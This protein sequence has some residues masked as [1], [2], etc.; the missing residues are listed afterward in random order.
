[1]VEGLWTI[2]FISS[3]NLWGGGVIVMTK[4][5]RILGGDTGYYYIGTYTVTGSQIKGDVDI[6]Q[7]DP[8]SISV[9]GETSDFHLTFDGAFEDNKFSAAAQSPKFPGH[10]IKIEGNKKADLIE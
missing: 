10:S 3:L 5:R 4:E 8:Q 1:M 2:K 6:I 7:F 9:F